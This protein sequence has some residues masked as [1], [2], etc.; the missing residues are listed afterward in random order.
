MD[1]VGFSENPLAIKRHPLGA[2]SADRAMGIR[3]PGVFLELL[4]IFLLETPSRDSETV[5]NVR[6]ADL[7][8]GNERTH[9][10]VAPD[11]LIKM[12]DLLKRCI[13]FRTSSARDALQSPPQIFAELISTFSTE[14]MSR[15]A[16]RDEQHTNSLE[17]ARNAL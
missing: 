4:S 1:F 17:F 15:L 7:A 9:R 2:E 3:R 8:A 14:A 16:K 11:P 10:F 12:H 6:V 5:D 13:G